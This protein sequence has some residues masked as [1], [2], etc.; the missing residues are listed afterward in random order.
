M[1]KS[2]LTLAALFALT[3]VAFA[4]NPNVGT[5]AQ[6][7]AQTS[8]DLSTTSSVHDAGSEAKPQPKLGYND[9]PWFITNLN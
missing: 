8:V 7:K 3:G 6:D 2:A 1:R 5:G 4:E 9:S